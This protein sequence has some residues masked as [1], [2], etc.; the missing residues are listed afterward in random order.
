MTLGIFLFEE[1]KGSG[2]SRLGVFHHF[3]ELRYLWK[4]LRV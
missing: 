1:D 4:D 3:L 2:G